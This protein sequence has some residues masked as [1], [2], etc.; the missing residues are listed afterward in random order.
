MEG[1]PLWGQTV[2]ERDWIFAARDRCGDAMDTIRAMIEP[3]ALFVWNF[4]PQTS[5]LNCRVTRRR[6]ILAWR[7][8][9]FWQRRGSLSSL[10]GS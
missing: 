3:D 7:Y 6:A 1:I 4:R 8:C 5:R 10:P 2:T 9:E